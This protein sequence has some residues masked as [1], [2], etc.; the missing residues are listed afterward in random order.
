MRPRTHPFPW[1]FALALI[2]AAPLRGQAFGQWWWDGVLGGSQRSFDNRVNGERVSRFDQRDFQLGLGVNGYI[3]HPAVARFR[4]GVDVLL[5]TVESGRVL[6][7]DRLG[8]S[9]TLNVLPRGSY[10]LTLYA[11]R[12]QFDYKGLT[13]D[14]P[15]L[16]V[17]TPETSTSWGGRLRLRRGPMRG[18]LLGLDHTQVAY[19]G[20]LDRDRVEDRQFADWAGASES[21]RRH[22]RLE[23]DY[24]DFGP[25]SFAIENLTLNL[26][27]HGEIR[28]REAG[29]SW[30][31]DLSTS[32]LRRNLDVG[33]RELSIDTL[34]LQNLLNRRVRAERDLLT[35]SYEGDWV[36]DGT[37][38]AVQSHAATARY[39]WQRTP[40]WEI[41]P[42]VRLGVQRGGLSALEAPQA[43]VSSTWHRSWSAA[44]A[45]LTGSLSYLL[46][47][48]REEGGGSARSSTVGSSLAASFAHGKREGLRK[49][50]ELSAARSE[51][52]ASGQPILDLPDLG[53]SLAG[54]GVQDLYR[55]RFSLER[56]VGRIELT[57]FFEWSRRE[58]A[59]DEVADAAGAF[60]V[61]T[62][63]LNLQAAGSILS[64]L[65]NAGQI[66]AQQQRTGR[67][68][69]DFAS[70]SL[71]LRLLRALSLRGAYRV[72]ERRV[73]IAPNIDGTRAEVGFDLALGEL[74]LQGQAFESRESV[75]GGSERMNRGYSVTLSRRLAGWLPFVSGTPR[76]GVIR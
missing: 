25:A 19:M 36:R 56:R 34:R 53:A 68:D 69:V 40:R 12:Q 46:L 59:S 5:S 33:E 18:T 27:Q 52:R 29:P 49:E 62:T 43:G 64:L 65:A 75:D 28:P 38:D 4:L 55:G 72:D 24:R 15:L 35:F 54:L 31:W 23:R 11:R 6:D 21:M 60:E 39:S 42:F 74:V 63:S 57:T 22:V 13:L 50:I 70:A 73:L 14:D 16:F 61:E 76:R 20:E 48:R 47:R 7:T 26:D 9:G 71:N 51:L 17:G 3:V 66:R 67:Q 1:M 45:S 44:D 58:S 10:P 2:T 41:T 30:R 37:F 8:Y 32:A